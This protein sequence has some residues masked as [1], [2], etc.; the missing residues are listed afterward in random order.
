MNTQY[1]YVQRKML[2]YI[3][4]S[5]LFHFINS[6]TTTPT[7]Q[8]L[9]TQTPGTF[10]RVPLPSKIA[11]QSQT[12]LN[13]RRYNQFPDIPFDTLNESPLDLITPFYFPVHLNGLPLTF[14]IQRTHTKR[15]SALSFLFS[16]G[17]ASTHEMYD[18]HLIPAYHSMLS[19]V[20]TE[21]PFHDINQTTTS[22]NTTL[23]ILQAS[24]EIVIPI[25]IGSL[26]YLL[27]FSTND[28]NTL[29]VIV[30]QFLTQIGI[31]ATENDQMIIQ[32]V[33]QMTVRINR[34]NRAWKDFFPNNT[35]EEQ[36]QEQDTSDTL[37]WNWEVLS[38]SQS[39]S[40]ITS[41]TPIHSYRQSSE[42]D[43]TSSIQL[44][45]W[46]INLWRSPVRRLHMRNEFSK[47]NLL[48]NTNNNNNNN[49]NNNSS[50]NNNI[51]VFN[52]IDGL[53]LSEMVISNV[54]GEGA[55]LSTGEIGCFL[56]H[57]TL[58]W[59]IVRSSLPYSVIIEDD[60]V[61]TDQFDLKLRYYLNL[62]NNEHQEWDFLMLEECGEMRS[63]EVD[64]N[65]RTPIYNSMKRNN[66]N[67]N[68][69]EDTTT[70]T[71]TTPSL[72][73]IDGIG[74]IPSGVRAYVISHSGALKL[75]SKAIPLKHA[76]DVYLAEM[77]YAQE[78]NAY[79]TLPNIVKMHAGGIS[80]SDTASVPVYHTKID[81]TVVYTARSEKD[82]PSCND[83]L[84]T[85]QYRVP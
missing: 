76:I 64:K 25:G 85:L 79:C 12:I 62:L 69:N 26:S 6:Q 32:I 41:K 82:Y 58:W 46:I 5:L 28:T 47:Q 59:S 42:N 61:L 4:T 67:N 19:Q 15:R 9:N 22:N 29:K 44:P 39:T 54:M 30:V 60:S 77:I 3:L 52:A 17:F 50:N 1:V 24:A 23:K 81:D 36:E 43:M 33:A 27:H 51:K 11:S 38:S 34:R 13:Q 80:S 20:S 56:S 45:I 65:C 73:K 35:I 40:T 18:N 78:I 7:T 68:N 74:C 37:L 21:H 53:S 70:R 63:N 8:P 83:I 48:F 10:Q 71:T 72:L 57:I 84:C 55:V 66:N 31:N 14:H 16:Q 49:S 75:A 2:K